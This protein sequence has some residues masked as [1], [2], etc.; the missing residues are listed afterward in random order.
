MNQ[1]TPNRNTKWLAPALNATAAATIAAIAIAFTTLGCAPGFEASSSS[2]C[3]A[4]CTNGPA[5][6]GGTGAPGTGWDGI[7]VGGAIN[8]GRFDKTRVI[9]IDKATKTLILR[10]PFI[11]GIK[12]GVQAPL[13]I[14]EI[15]GASIGLEESADGS[16]ALTL[17]L[18][19]DKV[20]HGVSFLPKGRLPNGDPL[21]AIPDGEL[22]SL[23]LSFDRTNSLKGALY[24]SPSVVGIFVNTKFDP[25]IKLTLPIRNDARTVTYGYFTSIPAKPNFDGGFFLSIALPADLARAIDDLL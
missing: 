21:P 4:P 12:I 6:S 25:F 24:L 5:G 16:S 11:A 2:S 3:A 17:R 23:G 13:N 9:E 14:P 19:L 15:P 18:P 7:N 22:P 1:H 8:G 10:V 20:L